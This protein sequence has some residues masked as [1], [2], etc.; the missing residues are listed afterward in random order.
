[1]GFNTVV[2]ILNDHMHSIAKAPKSFTYGLCHPPMNGED[3]Q[4]RWVEMVRRELKSNDEPYFSPDNDINI[5][6]TFHADD[7][8]FLYAGRNSLVRL[9]VHKYH[10]VNVNKHRY[11]LLPSE[12]ERKS[13]VTLI[14]PDW[15]GK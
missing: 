14:L 9:E 7:A 10:T 1:M 3:E 13:A 12:M 5:L 2:M 4:K 11:G 8:H 6:P 15:W